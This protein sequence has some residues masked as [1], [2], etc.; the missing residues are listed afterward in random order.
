[1]ISLVFFLVGVVLALLVGLWKARGQYIRLSLAKEAWEDF[2]CAV[3]VA[4]EAEMDLT[5]PNYPEGLATIER[6]RAEDA[7]T[8]AVLRLG[9]LGEY[10]DA[11]QCSLF[12]PHMDTY[13]ESVARLREL[14]EMERTHTGLY[15]PLATVVA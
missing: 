1:M 4:L 3:E 10:P 15:A 14:Q 5:D 13:A 7:A 8:L 6:D 9:E 2:A 12:L 11:H